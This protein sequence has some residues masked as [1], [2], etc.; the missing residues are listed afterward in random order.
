M[1]YHAISLYNL[2]VICN[3]AKLDTGVRMSSGLPLEG[4]RIIDLSMAL[5]GPYASQLLADLGAE[6]LKVEPPTGELTR[7]TPPHYIG[8]TSVYFLANNRNKKSISID[9]KKSEGLAVL[10]DLVK[11]SDVVYYNYSAGVPERLK[12]THE[13]LAAVNPK[14]I[15]CSVTGFGRK[16]PHAQ[17]PLVDN[18]AQSLAGAMS[19]TGEPD[20]PPSRAGVPTADLSAALYAC[21]GILASLQ[22]RA[23]TGKGGK[24][25]AALFHSQ[26]SL[27]NY[28]VPFTGIT[29]R[30]PARVGTGHLGNA[31]TK[32]FKTRDGW[33][34][35]EAGFNNHFQSLC[36]A[37]GR[38]ELAE[39]PRYVDRASRSKNRGSLTPLLDEAF[40][41]RSTDEWFSILGPK[42]IPCGPVN[43][44]PEALQHPQALE[45]RAV[46]KVKFRS[47]ELDVLGTPLWFNDVVEHPFRSP[48]EFGEHTVEILRDYL[49][50]DTERI[51]TLVRSEA[52]VAKANDE[53]RSDV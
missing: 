27:L 37:L 17:R 42:G 35:M 50:Y 41:Q 6:V 34:T 53:E 46:R 18:V 30:A 24:V 48:P 52:V 49:G 8:D 43:S 28:V 14:I 45:Y 1:F 29:G 7:T 15:T 11:V 21:I 2:V 22:S 4:I 38:P 32:T 5:A 40:A 16:G 3:A 44:V 36:E 9:L 20:G 47:S 25:E 26:L 39:D 19:I 33:F 23:R 12:I 10:L 51:Q 13:H 31:A